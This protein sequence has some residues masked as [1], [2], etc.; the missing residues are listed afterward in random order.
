[1]ISLLNENREYFSRLHD[2]SIEEKEERYREDDDYWL[3]DLDDLQFS[4]ELLD[5]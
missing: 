1:M 2:Y 4:S 5:K 3:E